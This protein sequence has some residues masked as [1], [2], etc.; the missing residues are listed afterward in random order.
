MNK[1][2]PQTTKRTVKRE[3]QQLRRAVHHRWVFTLLLIDLYQKV[4]MLSLG[5]NKK[6]SF[7]TVS[8]ALNSRLAEACR[9]KTKL[10]IPSRLNTAAE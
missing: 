3:T 10:F 1:P 4:A 6:L 2:T 7:Y 9:A 5:G 8:L